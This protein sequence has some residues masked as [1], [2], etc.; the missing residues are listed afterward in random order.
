MVDLIGVK[1]EHRLFSPDSQLAEA[2]PLFTP[3]S[4]NGGTESSAAELHLLGEWEDEMIEAGDYYPPPNDALGA[5]L[6][7][8]LGE[9]GMVGVG[10]VRGVS[11][12]ALLW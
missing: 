3:N 2:R 6:S 1:R 9:G 8:I 12:R 7:F 10:W 11:R 5:S 4:V